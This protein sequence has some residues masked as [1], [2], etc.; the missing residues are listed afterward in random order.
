MHTL[1][2]PESKYLS[3]LGHTLRRNRVQWNRT[4][5]RYWRDLHFLFTATAALLVLD[6]RALLVIDPL[7]AIFNP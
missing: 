6:L 2:R 7:L 4:R 3:A 1:N 5:R